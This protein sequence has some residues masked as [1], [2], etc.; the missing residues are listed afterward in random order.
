M[1]TSNKPDVSKSDQAIPNKIEKGVPIELDVTT[2]R[3]AGDSGDGIQV[4]GTR[5]AN[6]SAVFGKDVMT[7]AEYP[8]EIRAPAGTI[9]GVSGFQ[10][11]VGP[12]DVYTSGDQVD[13]LVAMNP[14]ALKS[15]IS[16]VA[17]DGIIILNEDSFT[18]KNLKKAGYDKNPINSG[19]LDGY[20]VFPI[21]IS[22]MTAT[23]LDSLG[24]PRVQV[25]RSKNFFALGLICWLFNLPLENS[26]EWVNTK[27]KNKEDVISANTTALQAGY[28]F[29]DITNLFS[30]SYTIKKPEKERAPGTYR[31][32]NGNTALSM[33]LIAAADL[34]GLHLFLGSY[35]ITPATDILHEL[36]RHK[37]FPITTFQA[38][39]E[40][41]A[42]GSAIGASFTGSLAVTTTSGPGMALKTEFINLAVSTELPLL[43]INVQR[44]GPSTGLPTKMEQSDLFQ[45]LWGRPGE[46]PIVVLAAQS[47][48][49]CFDI[50]IEAARIAIKYMTP[51]IILSDGYIANGSEPWLIPDVDSL[52]KID[53]KFLTNPENFHPFMRDEKT[54]ARPWVKP[55]TPDMVHRIGGLEKEDVTGEVN[56]D[57]ENHG[58]MVDLRA[59]KIEA[60]RDIIPD[61]KVEGDKDADLLIVG[62]GSTFG[63]ITRAVMNQAAKGNKVASIHLRY[64]NPFPGN[65]EEIL[66]QY[67][68]SIV[69][70][71]NSGQLWTK[72]RAE[73]L[74]DA[75]R[76]NKTKGNPFKISEIE[77]EIEMKLGGSKS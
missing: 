33:G 25:D 6:T 70:E 66:K 48:S 65:L 47:P 10:V 8:A 26:L 52:P 61:L 43:I 72:L 13:V 19:E 54:Y 50:T 58:V 36:C 27:F 60:V 16:L 73:F 49:D 46:S 56:Q 2:I 51:V 23:S 37:E 28:N 45:A 20:R 38:E 59:K 55:G 29:G 44:A 7:L 71:N 63:A 74:L 14:A 15:N 5:Y 9:A 76:L 17:E 77:E 12:Q 24:L 21:E 67:P 53:A 30:T 31:Y 34:A 40:I 32:L 75:T 11:N 18:E 39:D 57:T 68:K 41:A 3:F 42:I 35:P 4:L 69:V 1:E 64:L 62:W 22:K